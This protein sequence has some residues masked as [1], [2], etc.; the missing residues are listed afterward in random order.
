MK[1]TLVS[2]LCFTTEVFAGS[3]P[4]ILAESNSVEIAYTGWSAAEVLGTI[5]RLF[6]TAG[7][8]LRKKASRC[9]CLTGCRLAQWEHL[10][11]C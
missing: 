8:M 9:G 3:P 4:A 11:G 7:L 1:K 2:D 10:T 5:C 6:L